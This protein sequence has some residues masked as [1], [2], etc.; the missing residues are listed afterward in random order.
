MNPLSVDMRALK[1]EIVRRGV[2]Q[3]EVA[4]LIGLDSTAFSLYVNG[5]RTPPTDF[6]RRVTAALDRLER[7]EAAADEARQ[8]VLN[9][10]AREHR[11]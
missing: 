11:P 8:R 6:E 2:R 1:A 7:A 10:A 5:H 9:E 4:R 3:H